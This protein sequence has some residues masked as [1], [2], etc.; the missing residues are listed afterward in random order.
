MQIVFVPIRAF[1][2]LNHFLHNFLSIEMNEQF[3]HLE[4][5]KDKFVYVLSENIDCQFFR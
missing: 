5:Q 2:C 1:P 4:I 3:N